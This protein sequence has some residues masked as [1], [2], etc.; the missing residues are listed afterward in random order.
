MS[1]ITKNQMLIG[2]A[3]GVN[4]FAELCKEAGIKISKPTLYNKLKIDSPM[5]RNPFD[6]DKLNNHI[7][8]CTEGSKAEEMFEKLEAAAKYFAL[9]Y[10]LK[11]GGGEDNGPDPDLEPVDLP[12]EPL[13]PPPSV[14]KIDTEVDAAPSEYEPAE[15]PKKDA[16]G[17]ALGEFLN[18]Q[19][20]MSAAKT[21]ISDPFEAG[22]MN[23]P[24]RYDSDNHRF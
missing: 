5:F 7:A 2:L 13:P 21:V 9:V 20:Q 18:G 8:S 12:N 24:D 16:V 10:K 6:I 19:R 3:G 15:Q 17:G 11:N 23:I 22:L 1:N 4:E 14:I